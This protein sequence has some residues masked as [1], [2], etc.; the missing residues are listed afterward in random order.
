MHRYGFTKHSRI[1]KYGLPQRPAFLVNILK[2][3][4]S[5]YFFYISLYISSL[6]LHRCEKSFRTVSFSALQKKKKKYTRD[7]KY[8]SGQLVQQAQ[9]YRCYR[10]PTTQHPPKHKKQEFH[11]PLPQITC[12]R[13]GVFSISHPSGLV[14]LMLFAVT[15]Q[16]S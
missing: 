11:P 8:N 14:F 13:W 10:L 16:F 7:I 6:S 2:D 5:L 9:L 4:F 1:T 15:I 3:F 12:K